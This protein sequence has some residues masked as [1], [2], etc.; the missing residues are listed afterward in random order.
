MRAVIL[1]IGFFIGLIAVT[2]DSL[3]LED[4]SSFSVSSRIIL[5]DAFS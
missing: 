4:A 1:K 3:K 5:T 2:S